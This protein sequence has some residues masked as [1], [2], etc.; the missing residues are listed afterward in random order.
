MIGYIFLQTS[1]FP[2]MRQ[3]TLTLQHSLRMKQYAFF[4]WDAFLF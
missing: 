1:L 4:V 2:T 3:G